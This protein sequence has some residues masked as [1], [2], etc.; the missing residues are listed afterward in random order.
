MISSDAQAAAL[1]AKNVVNIL[2]V[3]EFWHRHN[4]CHPVTVAKEMHPKNPKSQPPI[5]PGDSKT[6]SGGKRILLVEDHEPTRLALEN[7]LKRRNYEVVSVA[8]VAEAR[9]HASKSK[10]DFLISDIGLPDGDGY[11][12]MGELQKLYGMGGIALTGYGMDEDIARSRRAGFLAHLTKPIHVR[13]LENAL[14]TFAMPP[15]AKDN[16]ADTK[17]KTDLDT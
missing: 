5:L 10:I 11:S 17:M 8:S 16:L 6:A 7:L 12:L 9:D 13:A 14:A 3:G 1:S 15:A 2:F 4:L